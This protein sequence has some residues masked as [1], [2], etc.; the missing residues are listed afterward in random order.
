MVGDRVLADGQVVWMPAVISQ[1]EALRKL[2]EGPRSRFGWQPC[3]F[4]LRQTFTAPAN[5]D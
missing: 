3:N 5:W 4:L 1:I 2:L